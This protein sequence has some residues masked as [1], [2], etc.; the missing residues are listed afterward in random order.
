M[1]KF[2]ME[3]DTQGRVR[4]VFSTTVKAKI[5]YGETRRN[6]EQQVLMLVQERDDGRMDVQALNPNYVPMGEVKVISRE[7]LVESYI[8]EPAMF[9]ERVV[10]AMRELEESVERGEEHY[11]KGETFSAEYEFKNALR[12]DEENVRA[13]FGL[14]LTFLDRGETA[15]GGLVFRR[16]VSLKGAF[17]PRH[18]HLF[19]EFGIKL[20]KNCMYAEA[21][22]FYARALHLSRDD[23]HLHYNMSRTLLAKGK[24]KSAITFL[25]KALALNPDFA[26]A[27]ELLAVA[28]RRFE[29]EQAS[30]GNGASNEPAQD[31]AKKAKKSPKAHKKMK[32]KKDAMSRESQYKVG[33]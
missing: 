29:A 14:G 23:E 21:L 32:G 28:Q 6:T 10:P 27:R 9:M 15:K 2:W 5:G 8:P 22:K 3:P 17:E 18:K 12:I 16:L 1:A 33:I 7:K 24:P 25:R 19:N 20:R 30:G 4:G 31:K 26:E 11:N 13:T